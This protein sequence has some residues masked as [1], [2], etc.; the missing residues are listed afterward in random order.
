MFRV[1]H[2]QPNLKALSQGGF[3]A[4]MHFHTEHSYD[5]ST[6]VKDIV[7]LA[8]RLGVHVAITDHNRVGGVL[9]ALK[10]KDAPI[11]PGIEICTKEGK[12]VIPYF[13][14]AGQ[15]EE[16]YASK[17]A[18]Y[19]K[20]KNA[21]RSART[22]LPMAQLF[23]FLER[24]Q[25]VVHVPHPFAPMPRWS[26]RY[27][28]RHEAILK[29]IES[30]EVFNQT[31]TR[32]AN[33]LAAGWAVELGRGAAG[34]SDGH[35]LGLLGKG[36]TVSAATTVEEHLHSIRRANVQVYGREFKTLTRVLN[37]ARNAGKNKL[38]KGINGG[39]R[40]LTLQEPPP[41]ETQ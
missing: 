23:E 5:C 11:I 24:E 19:V 2:Q 1:F 29:R 28:E 20:E 7:K 14:D 10:H 25:C 27:F 3:V 8:K 33:M 4:D 38:E 16:F 18:Y 12:E 41:E 17:L 39:I 31:M 9:E 6:R 32:R 35:A 13:Y 37:Y 30:V 40:K 22:Q 26:H 36:V 21:M 15:L 34:G